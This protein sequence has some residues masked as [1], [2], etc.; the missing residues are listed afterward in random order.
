MKPDARQRRHVGLNS[1]HYE[2]VSHDVPDMDMDITTTDGMC[3][4]YGIFTRDGRR[5]G[6]MDERKS[7]SLL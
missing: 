6:R 2:R 3:V 1:S 7:M 4:C 5:G